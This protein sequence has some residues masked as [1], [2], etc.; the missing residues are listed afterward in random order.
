M[1]EAEEKSGDTRQWL[2]QWIG[3]ES[4]AVQFTLFS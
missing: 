2:P 1:K 4:A 3:E